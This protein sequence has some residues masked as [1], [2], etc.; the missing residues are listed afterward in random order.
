MISERPIT[1][2]LSAKTKS[3]LEKFLKNIDSGKSLIKF[4]K[5]AKVFSQGDT[6]TAI[7]FILTGKVQ[8]TVVSPQ[9]KTAELARL[10]AR[11]FM[12]EECLVAESRR[13][14]TA[15]TLTA[16]S[17]FRVMKRAMLRALHLDAAF[18]GEF[19]TSLLARNINL[20]EDLTDQLFNHSEKRLAAALLK[21]TRQDRRGDS[22]DTKLPKINQTMLAEI[23][24]T[25]TAKVG[26]FMK[27][28][29]KLGLIDY[30]GIGRISVNVGRL[31]EAVL[32]D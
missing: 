15:T 13:S 17:I 8:L 16:S 31:T 32:H 25:T 4:P 28:F 12:G 20:E 1:T 3:A 14:S 18:S 27:K 29:R 22:T 24:G 10:G 7:F 19:M 5:G 21:F 11:D 9:G 2:V 23:I 6:G 30:K 26:G